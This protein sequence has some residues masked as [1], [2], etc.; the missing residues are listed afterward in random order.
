[1]WT[2]YIYGTNTGLVLAC[3]QIVFGEPHVETSH[4]QA[5]SIEVRI[6]HFI[7]EDAT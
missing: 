3:I 6:F 5:L 4:L 1:M 2:R 7:L